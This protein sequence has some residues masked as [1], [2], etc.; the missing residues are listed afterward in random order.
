[1]QRDRALRHNIRTSG[2]VR[3]V[4]GD[5]VYYKRVDNKKWRGPGVV[6]GQDGKQVLL[7]HQ[8]V[9][10]RVHPCRLTLERETIVGLKDNTEESLAGLD[11]DE[12]EQKEDD[13]NS[14][15]N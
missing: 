4:T 9:Y 11:K 3:Y 7:K 2:E 6:L 12:E 1:M 13:E 14:I 15:D 8:G 5:R 10:V